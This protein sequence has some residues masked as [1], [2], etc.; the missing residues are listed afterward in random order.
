MNAFADWLF[1]LLLGWTGRAANSVWNALTNNTQGISSFFSQYW[2]PVL[3]VL[4]VGG[5]IADYLVWFVR[6]R[7]HYVWRS[8]FMMRDWERQLVGTEQ[9]MEH[10]EMPR[11][12]LREIAGWVSNQE[13]APMPGLWQDAAP[14]EYDAQL[15]YA[16]DEGFYAQGD[17]DPRSDFPAEQYYD[18][19]GDWQNIT[20]ATESN[21]VLPLEMPLPY[22]DEYSE[23]LHGSGG[24]EDEQPLITPE[25]QLYYDSYA[26]PVTNEEP[27]QVSP[28][29]RR[30][31]RTRPMGEKGSQRLSRL[32]SRL[33]A[34]QDDDA[35]LDGLPPPVSQDDAFHRPV[36]PDS[37]RAGYNDNSDAPSK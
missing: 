8:K 37:Y 33:P 22:M 29:R 16:P 4:V 13:E 19:P 7:P 11:E 25:M 27:N 2:L 12:Y 6:W 30:S 23:E 1:S 18:A 34:K 20:P 31:E 21:G 24:R 9:T 3:I 32:L 26:P 17:G 5:T 14:T 35:I 10:G 15:E 36:Y 28:R